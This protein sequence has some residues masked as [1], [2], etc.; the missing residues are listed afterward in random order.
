MEQSTLNSAFLARQALASYR[1][2][3]AQLEFIRHSDTL[4][5]QM[6]RLVKEN[7]LLRPHLPITQSMG[8]HGADYASLTSKLLW[9]EALC[10]DK[11]LQGIQPAVTDGRIHP[12]D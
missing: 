4:S 3:A 2:E 11:V 8:T 12:S 9:Q 7:F 1:L 10:Q 5:Y 6:R